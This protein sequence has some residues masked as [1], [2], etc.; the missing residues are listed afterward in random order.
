MVNIFVIGRLGADAEI[1]TKK[2]GSSMMTFNVAVDDFVNG[3]KTTTW[4]RVRN[5]NS[6][7]Q[8]QYLKKGSPVSISGVETVST[9]VNKAGETLISRDVLADRIEFV[10]T[11][12]GK[13]ENTR[14]TVV[15]EIA[16]SPISQVSS[17]SD[18]EMM[19][20]GTFAPQM[21]SATSAAMDDDDLPF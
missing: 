2:D 19:S 13:T 6:L 16:S 14:E 15:E 10:K 9:F 4:L 12:S 21:A 11:N 1:R 20:C 18:E 5:T 8:A 17:P 7:H 3:T